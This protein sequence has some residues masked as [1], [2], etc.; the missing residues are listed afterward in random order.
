M[1][2]HGIAYIHI[3]KSNAPGNSFSMKKVLLSLTRTTDQTTWMVSGLFF[4]TIADSRRM[5]FKTENPLSNVSIATLLNQCVTYSK[6]REYTV[7]AYKHACLAT[8]VKMVFVKK[9]TPLLYKQLALTWL[10]IVNTWGHALANSTYDGKAKPPVVVRHTK[11]K[12]QILELQKK[13]PCYVQVKYACYS[14]V[15]A[16]FEGMCRLVFTGDDFVMQTLIGVSGYV[17]TYLQRS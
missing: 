16:C 14:L 13:E 1:F 15:M 17:V 5:T 9:V 7:G 11:D 6:G 2:K 3:S 4:L 8:L 10:N 12:V